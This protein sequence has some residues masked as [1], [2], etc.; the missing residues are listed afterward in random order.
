MKRL[1]FV[2]MFLLCPLAFGVNAFNLPWMN[3]SD[4]ETRY[5]SADH[6]RGIFVIE[7]FFLNCPYCNDNAP[8]VDELAE[9]YE[10]EERVQVLDL[11][12]DRLDS[13]YDTWIQ[14]HKPNH[15][16]LKD[17]K[18]VVIQQL[19]TTGYPSAYILDC[20]GKVHYQTSGVWNATKKQAIHSTIDRLLQ[21]ECNSM[22]N[23]PFILD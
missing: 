18:R 10:N 23:L 20:K 12:I 22:V 5:W 4:P 7:T 16:V 13:Q 17:D 14:R 9:E 6:P 8:N 2:A 19:G 11:G 15:P 3:H 21:E 1:A